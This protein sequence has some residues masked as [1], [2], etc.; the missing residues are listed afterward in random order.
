MG[1]SITQGWA[2]QPYIKDNA[3][4]VS[5]G[6]S[7]QTTPQMLVRFRSDV[8]ALK[9][10]VVHIMAGTNDIAQNTG[11]ESPR[12]LEGYIR[13]MVELALANKIKV[14]L[15]SIPP[16]KDFPWHRGLI[17]APQIH[18][19]NDWLKEYAARRGLVYVN[20]WSA[21][22][23]ADGAMKPEYSADGVHPNVVGYDAMRPLA[24]AAIKNALVV[25]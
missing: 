21:L 8:I 7:G 10:A 9:P 14:V 6:I 13:S 11:P 22:A 2:G 4:F 18:A 16:A 20:Y 24:Q 3:N 25:R 5:R 17:P 23:T 12:E 19:L 15:A 1:D